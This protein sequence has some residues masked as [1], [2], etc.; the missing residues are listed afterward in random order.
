M[1]KA[2]KLIEDFL[3]NGGRYYYI[4]AIF[5]L[6]FS[7][8]YGLI[9][10]LRRVLS[11]KRSYPIPIIS[12]GNL[13]V[14]GAGK[15]PFVIELAKHLELNGIWVILRGYGRKSR[16]LLIVS[17]GE[18]ILSSVDNSGDEAMLIAKSLLKFGVGVIV[19]EDR[20]KAVDRAMALGAKVI[21]LDDGFNRVNIK[22]FE[23]LLEPKDIKNR[24]VLPL[25]AFREFP[26]SYRF[27]NLILKEGVDFKRVVKYENL[28]PAML[29][30][31]SISRANRLKPYLPKGVI[32]TLE[33][34]DHSFFNEDELKGALIKYKA[35]SLL[36]TEKDL[37]KLESFKLPLS[38]MRLELVIDESVFKEINDYIK[39]FYEKEVRDS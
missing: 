14:G 32:A 4:F 33:L 25:G 30:A 15:T 28:T 8:V 29:L 6:P 17:D 26:F 16:G 10:L 27:A 39:E 24:A 9:M 22:K 21:I 35:N 23:I 18:R 12:V 3:F 2:H 36:V 19:S 7:I 38:L 1:T 34:K 20:V 13:V 11:K 5:L 37:V 31:T